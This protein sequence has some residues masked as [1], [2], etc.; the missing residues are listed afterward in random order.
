MVARTR[1]VD[2]EYWF[3]A[4]YAATLLST[5][6]QKV[7]AMAVRGLVR[8]KPEGNS[9]LIAEPDVTRLRRD[10]SA[11][12]EFKAAAKMPARPAK[13]EAM[14]AA[15]IYKGDP[16]PQRLNMRPSIGHPLKDQ[17]PS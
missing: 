5:S 13:G 14:P 6:R 4:K 16:S 7:E 12:K 15:T 3:T 2:G 17:G 8:S 11:L 10:P 9:F 1:K